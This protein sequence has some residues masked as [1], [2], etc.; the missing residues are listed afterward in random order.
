MCYYESE[1]LV[2]RSKLRLGYPMSEI[3]VVEDDD[4][5]DDDDVEHHT[6][7]KCW[8]AAGGQNLR[9]VYVSLHL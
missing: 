4:V 3:G 5:E 6:A 9:G 8:P 1:G 7:L 2:G